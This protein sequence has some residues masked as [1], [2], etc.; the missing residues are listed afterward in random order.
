MT[1][2]EKIRLILAIALVIVTFTAMDC[3]DTSN[4]PS[5]TGQGSMTPTKEV[6]DPTPPTVV[7]GH[8]PDGSRCE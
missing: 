7:V 3:D 1:T 6:Y 2:K 5:N 4:G 8:G